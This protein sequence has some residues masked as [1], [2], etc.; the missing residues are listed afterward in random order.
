MRSNLA[1]LDQVGP[2]RAK[3]L[4]NIVKQGQTMLKRLKLG[5]KV[6]NRGN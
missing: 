5:L 4:P 3:H 6:V 2:N 1:K